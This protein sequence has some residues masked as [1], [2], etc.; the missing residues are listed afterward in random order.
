MTEIATTIGATVTNA[1]AST[2]TSTHSAGSDDTDEAA[3]ASAVLKV[4]R[5]EPSAEELA[6]L[7]AVIAS[8][9]AGAAGESAAPA[10]V[11]GWTDRSR[12]V[13]PVGRPFPGG[14]RSSAL[15]R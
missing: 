10:K 1:T 15:P 13:R 11:S 2:S 4:V 5:G 3:N 9:V 6:A 14:W 8:Q 12:Y 7:V